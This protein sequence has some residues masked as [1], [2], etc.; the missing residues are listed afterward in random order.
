VNTVIRIVALA[1]IAIAATACSQKDP[2]A[3]AIAA[4]EGALAAVYDDAQKYLPER[5]AEV[6]AELDAGRKAFDEERYAD[7]ITAVKEVPAHAE[8]LSKEVVAA[9]QKKLSDLN[10][11][12][13]RLSGSLPGLMTSIGARLAELGK[14]R[15]LPAGMDK[16]LLDEANAAHAS[17]NAAWDE[18]GQAFN[19]GD[20]EA[21][22]AKARDAEGTAQ[23]LVARL[24]MQAG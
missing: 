16:Q 13:A 15:R 8:A 21:A 23:D 2:A 4:A 7:A 5:Y 10:A 11:D 17:A 24:G 6:K 14:M 18:A 22:V 19:A 12:W 20:L 1:A 3:D 9:K